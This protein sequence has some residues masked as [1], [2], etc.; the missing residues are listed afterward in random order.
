MPSV[1]ELGGYALFTAGA[2]PHH[3]H[4]GVGRPGVV[5]LSLARHA[6]RLAHDTLRPRRLLLPH[7]TCHSMKAAAARLGT[8]VQ[9][10]HLGEGFVP[11]L[12]GLRA[13][14]LCVVNNH[15]GLAALNAAWQQALAHASVAQ[16]LVDNT[17]SLD[18]ERRWPDCWSVQS[19]RKFLPV[20]D[21]GI[22]VPPDSQPESSLRLPETTDQSWQRVGWL[23]RGLDEGTRSTSYAEYLA[24]RRDLVQNIPYAL[25]SPTTRQLLQTLDVQGV[26][27]QRQARFEDLRRQLP[28][29]AGCQHL[30]LVAGSCPI[31][32]PVQVADAAQAQSA[33]ARHRIFAIRY[34]PEEASGGQG[35]DELNAFERSWRDQ[36]L[37]LPLDGDYDAVRLQQVHDVISGVQP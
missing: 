15:F 37:F 16:R 36:A 18:L 10:Y 9:Y 27:R 24:Y 33:L 30:R 31:G 32:F 1:N 2:W 34:W 22:V 28:L 20:T 3:D 5:A 6:L 19:P 12:A 25:A 4:L 23:F 35:S 21:G 29:H 8:E 7:Y 14:D 17:Q 26:I 11:D 13:D